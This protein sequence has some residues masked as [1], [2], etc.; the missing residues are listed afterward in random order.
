MRKGF[1]R[2]QIK[3]SDWAAEFNSPKG[4]WVNSTRKLCDSV[5]SKLS[6]LLL[7]QKKDEEF[8]RRFSFTCVKATTLNQLAKLS[9]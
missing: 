8:G 7:I 1:M 5:K 4:G 2:V 3:H 6:L 9:G